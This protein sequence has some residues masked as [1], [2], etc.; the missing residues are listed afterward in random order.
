[1]AIDFGDSTPV[2]LGGANPGVVAGEDSGL[3]G[4][5]AGEDSGV[6]GARA[7]RGGLAGAFAGGEAAGDFDGGEAAGDLRG[8]V[9]GDAGGEVAGMAGGGDEVA[10]RVSTSSFIPAAQCPGVAQMKYLLPGDVSETV[11]EP[12]V[13]VLIGLVAWHE[14]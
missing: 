4:A 5:V 11:V 6:V 9:A 7:E 1:M 13:L 3:V 8:G 10:A 14:S 12:P 2:S